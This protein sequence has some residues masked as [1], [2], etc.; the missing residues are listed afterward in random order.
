MTESLIETVAQDV[1]EEP[2][3][4]EAIVNEFSLQ[5]HR[6][7]YEYQGLNGNYV[8][9]ALW[10]DVPEQAFYHLLGLISVITEH[11]PDPYPSSEYLLRLGGRNRW[12]TY[13]HQMDGWKRSREKE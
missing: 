6:R 10:R 13:R 3:V 12:L 9:E 8:G 1:G 11:S 5:L 2:E 4:V 7:I